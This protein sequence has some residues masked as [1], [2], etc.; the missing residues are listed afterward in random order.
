[1]RSVELAFRREYFSEDEGVMSADF[2]YEANS[3]S[4]FIWLDPAAVSLPE[5]GVAGSAEMLC[6][7]PQE[8]RA[9]Y[10]CVEGMLRSD[11]Q[12]EPPRKPFRGVKQG[13]YEEL[14]NQLVE[15]GILSLQKE[16]PTVI[17]GIFGVPKGEKQRLIIDARNANA[18]FEEPPKVELPNPGDLAQLIM[19]QK[20]PL[21]VAKSDMDNFYH[22]LRMPKWLRQYFGLPQVTLEGEQWWPI[23]RVLPMGWSHSVYVGQAVHEQLLKGVGIPN[24]EKVGLGRHVGTFKF[25]AYIDDYFSLGTDKNEAN[26]WLERVVEACQR[27][28]IPAKEG[29]VIKAGE[30]EV[31]PVLGIEIHRGGSLMPAKERV[32]ELLKHTE[33]FLR[34]RAWNKRDLQSLLGK[35]AWLLL[36]N[37]PLFSVLDQVFKY[38][39][40]GRGTI[41]PSWTA[42]KELEALISLSPMI[43]AKVDLDLG[44]TIV[45]TDAS[46]WGAGVVYCRTTK[47]EARA[48]LEKGGEAQDGWI[49]RQEW[50][51]A[52][53]HPWEK[54]VYIHL[55]EGEATIIGLKWLLRARRNLGKRLI[56]FTDNQTLLGALR[57]GRSSKR[58]L[59]KICRRVA[60]LCTGGQ[61]RLELFYVKSES[62]PADGPS[63]NSGKKEVNPDA[64]KERTG[65]TNTIRP[66]EQQR[67]GPLGAR[68]ATCE[69]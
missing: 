52:I 37:R 12:E 28:G 24:E 23:V 69:E 11:A 47:E 13:L 21:Y 51:T 4:P 40:E 48:L 26:K 41:T 42:R 20:A 61:V 19:E 66:N 15:R 68:P 31:T 8:E 32:R 62:N 46:N 5:E 49:R 50:T 17:N 3:R 7:L 45:C 67:T 54:S 27:A 55:L 56:M 30:S 38:A 63:R 33:S 10:E 6:L 34:R 22:R 36:L 64:K 1:M 9:R 16:E 35:W 18:L 2:E 59:N 57:K 53:S 60:A 65:T 44:E 29:K 58:S 43:E 25:G 14:V 39:E